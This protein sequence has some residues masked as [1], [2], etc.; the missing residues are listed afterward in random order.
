MKNISDELLFQFIDNELGKEEYDRLKDEIENSEELQKRVEKLRNLTRV[1][2][3]IKPLEPSPYFVLLEKQLQ[4][5]K[6]SIIKKYSPVFAV[7]LITIGLMIFYKYNLS[8]FDKAVKEQ[9]SDLL[10]FYTQNLKPLFIK[11]RLDVNDVFQF[12]FNRTLPIDKER[13]QYLAIGVDDSG[14][15][16]FEI[17]NNLDL[18]SDRTREDFVRQLNLNEIQ[19]REL[20]SILMKYATKLEDQ[21]VVSENNA[22]GVNENLWTLNRAIVA[23]VLQFAEKAS[24]ISFEKI[25]PT[26]VSFVS[27]PKVDELISFA[28]NNKSDNYVLLTPDTIVS[29]P[30]KVEIKDYKKSIEEHSKNLKE[31]EKGMKEYEKGMKEFEIEMQKLGDE[32]ESRGIKISINIDTS[33]KVYR[34]HRK[35]KS[36]KIEIDKNICRIEIPQLE[37]IEIPNIDSVIMNIDEIQNK[38]RTFKIRPPKPPKPF[39][40]K[41]FKLDINVLGDSLENLEIIIPDLMKLKMNK[42][43]LKQFEMKIQGLDSLLKLGLKGDSLLKLGLKG[44]EKYDWE[45]FGKKMDSLGKSFQFHF[46]GEDFDKDKFKEE[47][48]KF[49]KDIEKLKYEYKYKVVPKDKKKNPEED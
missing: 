15:D 49:K 40:P 42:D 1:L 25:A 16:Y 11:T 23:N 24:K 44:I 4:A 19:Q 12:A 28:I 34:N 17:R 26:A 29:T 6:K 48:E 7:V 46:K 37:K 3:R 41:D 20:D 47:M 2:K 10:S 18:H 36:F 14:K 35:A 27:N 45:E 32:L 9:S 43:S 5:K 39:V 31:I 22:I 13:N 30:L 8:D 21:V 33:S 38:F